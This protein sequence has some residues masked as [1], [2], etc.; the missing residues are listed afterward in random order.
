ME[1][2]MIQAILKFSQLILT[3]KKPQTNQKNPNKQNKQT[4]HQKTPS[5]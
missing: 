2:F 4:T 1:G 5:C 3:I